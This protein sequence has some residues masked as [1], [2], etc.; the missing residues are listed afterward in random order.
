MADDKK[1]QAPHEAMGEVGE[2]G[3]TGDLGSNAAGSAARTAAPAVKPV[4]LTQLDPAARREG[5]VTKIAE[6]LQE[7]GF[8]AAEA[9]TMA[10]DAAQE[11]AERAKRSV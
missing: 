4:S 2:L 5:A 11:A 7:L 1:T 10:H 9:Q 6:G 3:A 8:S